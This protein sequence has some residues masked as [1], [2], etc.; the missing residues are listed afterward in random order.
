MRANLIAA[1]VIAVVVWLFYL[2]LQPRPPDDRCVLLAEHEERKAEKD[3]QSSMTWEAYEDLLRQTIALE[4]CKSSP[5]RVPGNMDP[6]IP[7]F[8]GLSGRTN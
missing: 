7:Y 4:G 8:G 5:C 1:G 3:F 2:L 6:V